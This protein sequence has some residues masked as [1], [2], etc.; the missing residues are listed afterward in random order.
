MLQQPIVQSLFP[1]VSVLFKENP[2]YQLA[3]TL[4]LMFVAFIFQVKASPYL[5]VREKA[6]LMRIQAEKN[7]LSE[8]LRLERQSLL[9]RVQG[10]SYS[11]LMHTMRAQI[12]EQ[13][14]IMAKHKNDMFNL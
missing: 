8:V 3:A 12:D 4:A 5:D 7:I 11:Q 10:Q 14:K 13:D 9:V 1:R 2:T 6:K